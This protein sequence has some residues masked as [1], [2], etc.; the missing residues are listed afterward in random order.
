[1]PADDR[2]LF[3]SA[4][5][6]A[7]ASTG[8][9]R[10]YLDP[11]FRA[12]YDESTGEQ[13]RADDPSGV[14][15]LDPDVRRNEIQDAQGA[16]GEVVFPDATPPFY[17]RE[18]LLSGPPTP[19]E[20]PNRRAGVQALN[21]WMADFCGAFPSRR[22]GVGTLVLND[23]DD[24][25]ADL[26]WMAGHGLRGGVQLPNI[27]P[28]VDWI[29]HLGTAGY[30]R[31]WAAIQDF[32]LTI[33]MH[34]EGGYP[35]LEMNPE[36]LF[37]VNADGPHGMIRNVVLMILSG[38]FDRFP[39]L[40]VA[41]SE[42]PLQI[43]TNLVAFLDTPYRLARDQA[44]LGTIPIIPGMELQHLPGDYLRTNVWFTA[45]PPLRADLATVESAMG[46]E[47]LMVG[48]DYP[49]H[50][51]AYPFTREA[52]RQMFHDRDEPTIRRVLADNPAALYGFDVSVLEVE[53]ARV[54]PTVAELAEPVV[55]LPERANYCL[56][57]NHTTP[58]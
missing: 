30:D 28:N 46:F 1:M 41:I 53:A 17:P 25:L 58:G 34:V 39:R 10:A 52:L 26:E 44:V 8:T 47:Q 7:S 22:A 42:V 29:P 18:I 45:S 11:A 40:R 33:N 57:A 32:D 50:E 23:L 56:V 19:A 36:S 37:L 21:R 9:Y 2:Y 35:P 24:T 49:H 48:N 31:L 27:T 15:E 20:Y 4:D 5:T 12:A 38:V 51:S 54:G 13:G 16:V 14:D 43:L 6:H 3:I 55:E